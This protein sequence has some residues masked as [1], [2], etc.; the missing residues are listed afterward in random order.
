[1]RILRVHLLKAFLPVFIGSLC[2]FVLIFE[3]G[4]L[5]P[6]L[7][8]YVNAD[9]GISDVS[10]LALYYA[11][12]C[13]SYSIP[14]CLLFAASFTLG[15]L[16]AN[17]ELIA[18]FTSGVSIR[19]YIVPIAAAGLL[20]SFASFFFEDGIVIAAN[21]AKNEIS[22]KILKQTRSKNQA[23][24]IVMSGSGKIVY[25]AYFYN[26]EEKSLQNV[27]VTERSADG[28]FLFKVV[29]EKAVFEDGAWKFEKARLF[30]WNEKGDALYD[31]FVNVFRRED[32]DEP[33]E[34][35]RKRIKGIEELTVAEAGLYLEQRAATGFPSSAEMADYHKRFAFALTP[36]I[37]VLISSSMGG[38]FKKN[39]LVMS[40]VASLFVAVVYYVMQMISMLYAEM[41]RIPP[42]I[43]AWIPSI[44]FLAVG[45]FLA[46][47]AKT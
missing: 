19:R 37:V 45:G 30:R 27:T 35:F 20:I 31:Q 28:S 8:R 23:N 21:R 44:A 5:L 36:F 22:Q 13:L 38:W 40:L 42:F 39:V 29:A 7:P 11:P 1:L 14:I 18:V 2:L 4:D 17:N 46:A 43:G 34:M 24:L 41:G 6:N 32:I 33:P 16:Y 3:L 15:S 9:A 26:D 25:Q 12:Q 10:L 47:Y